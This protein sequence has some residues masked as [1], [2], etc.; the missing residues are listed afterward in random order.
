MGRTVADVAV[1]FEAIAGPDP[2]DPESIPIDRGGIAPGRQPRIAFSPKLGLDVPVDQDV[3]DRIAAAVERLASAG[4]QVRH[5]DPHWPPGLS[6][7]NV[8]PLQQAGL[9]ALHG[10]RWRLEPHLFDPDIGAQ[11]ERGL[12][13]HGSDIANAL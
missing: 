4:Y 9:A 5:A 12:A 2:A 1:L 10:S 7:A 13:L 6:E 11:I 3:A 8:M